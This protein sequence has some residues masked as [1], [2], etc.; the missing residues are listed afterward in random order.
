MG[1]ARPTSPKR[2]PLF[3]IAFE[4]GG[5]GLALC[6]VP[7]A[8]ARSLRSLLARRDWGS[9]V[10][11][12]PSASLLFEIAFEPG[13]DCACPVRCPPSASLLFEI[14]FEPRRDW[15]C[16]VRRPP[17]ASL[18]FEIAFEPRRDWDCP[19]RRPPSASCSSRSLLSQGI[20]LICGTSACSSSVR[21]R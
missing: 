15:T 3:E 20:S 4:P 6:D 17:S 10:R 21:G 2:E 18:L 13:K 16:P 14:A 5:T 12:P 11:R 19:V 9:P 1:L 7:Q 8:R